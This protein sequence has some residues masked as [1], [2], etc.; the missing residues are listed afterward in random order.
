MKKQRLRDEFSFSRKKEGRGEE[1]EEEEEN[2]KKG[3]KSRDNTS[4]S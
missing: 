3:E 2:R 4:F 1:W